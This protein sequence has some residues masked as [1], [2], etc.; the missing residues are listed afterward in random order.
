M[1]PVTS[2]GKQ[3]QTLSELWKVLKMYYFH[4]SHWIEMNYMY[5]PKWILC[6]DVLQTLIM[7]LGGTLLDYEQEQC[8][9]GTQ[10]S[11]R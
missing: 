2:V 5:M 8:P 9:Y 11:L 3:F 10:P 1:V 6:V 7:K 4:L